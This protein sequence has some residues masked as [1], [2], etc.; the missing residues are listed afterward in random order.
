MRKTGE[1]ACREVTY[2]D[3]GE[4]TGMDLPDY[5]SG[6]VLEHDSFTGTEE[7]LCPL[8]TGSLRMAVDTLYSNP[9]SWLAGKRKRKPAGIF[10]DR[11]D[12]GRK[13]G[14]AFGTYAVLL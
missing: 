11:G 2:S 9:G 1:E 8:F 12:D 13:Q 10:R 5:L 14:G 4:I 6:C 3:N 7:N